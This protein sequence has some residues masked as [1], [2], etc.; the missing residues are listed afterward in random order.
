[1]AASAR[2]GSRPASAPAAKQE[3]FLYV[4]Y[5]FQDRAAVEEVKKGVEEGLRDD[6]GYSCWL[7]ERRLDYGLEKRDLV[8]RM[9]QK[10]K[11]FLICLSS[12]SAVSSLC[13]EEITWAHTA[14]KRL[15]PIWLESPK[16]MRFTSQSKLKEL[17]ERFKFKMPGV[18]EPSVPEQ[19]DVTVRALQQFFATLRRRNQYSQHGKEIDLADSLPAG[20]RLWALDRMRA[21]NGVMP[22]DVLAILRQHAYALADPGAASARS[23]ADG[24]RTLH[25][26]GKRSGGGFSR[27]SNALKAANPGDTVVIEPGIYEEHI[28]LD[29]ELRIV[30]GGPDEHAVVIEAQG[31]P[32]LACHAG[33]AAVENLTLSMASG[34]DGLST[35]EI[36][37]GRVRI[38]RCAIRCPHRG[39]AAISASRLA[40]PTIEFCTIRE[41]VNAG[42]IIDREITA[43]LQDCRLD[44]IAGDG[45]IIHPATTAQV[46][47]NVIRKCGGAGIR[48][49]YQAGG[50]IEG[51]LIEL[52]K[53]ETILS[54]GKSAIDAVIAGNDLFHNDTKSIAAIK[55]VPRIYFTAN[56]F[57][58]KLEN[59]PYRLPAGGLGRDPFEETLKRIIARALLPINPRDVAEE[60]DAIRAIR[61]DLAAVFEV[62]EY[63]STTFERAYNKAVHV[64]VYSQGSF[65]RAE[66]LARVAGRAGARVTA[67]LVVPLVSFAVGADVSERWERIHQFYLDERDSKE[68]ENE[69]LQSLIATGMA[70]RGRFKE[71]REALSNPEHRHQYPW[72]LLYAAGNL[73]RLAVGGYPGPR[74]LS[75][76]E[77]E[78]WDGYARRVADV[79]AIYGAEETNANMVRDWALRLA[80]R[81]VSPTQFDGAVQLLAGPMFKIGRGPD[82]VLGAL[83]GAREA[84]N[85]A[86]A[87]SLLKTY[88]AD[89]WEREDGG[90]EDFAFEISIELARLYLTHCGA[91]QSLAEAAAAAARREEAGRAAGEVAVYERK[92]R[93]TIARAG[94]EVRSKGDIQQLTGLIEECLLVLG[95]GSLAELFEIVSRKGPKNVPLWD[96]NGFCM[97]WASCLLDVGSEE[98]VKELEHVARICEPLVEAGNA[99]ALSWMKAAGRLLQDEAFERAV[100]NLSRMHASGRTG[101]SEA[102]SA[103]VRAVRARNGRARAATMATLLEE[104]AGLGRDRLWADVHIVAIWFSLGDFARA[105]EGL[106]YAEAEFDARAV[107]A[108]AVGRRPTAADRNQLK[109]LYDAAALALARRGGTSASYARSVQERARARSIRLH[110]SVLN[111]VARASRGPLVSTA[112]VLQPTDPDPLLLPAEEAGLVS[113]VLFRRRRPH[114]DHGGDGGEEGRRE[115]RGEDPEGGPAPDVDA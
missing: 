61:D 9:I 24:P 70:M 60:A 57:F 109:Y 49:H 39:A 2:S 94:R 63:V 17:L 73:A 14:G 76:A 77:R 86:G 99:H 50:S 28:V 3:H 112:V 71:A 51:N 4:S 83:Q 15:F 58:F 34:R 32:A 6:G 88:A 107:A 52:C 82:F 30:G 95:P 43:L 104:A 79:V 48:L 54:E 105:W 93:S 20:V 87:E 101:P 13:F 19:V 67:A 65:E 100:Q 72:T 59:E 44:A 27:I 111:R 55:E 91:L 1:M 80:S 31:H 41:C 81:S 25:V 10:S 90:M 5:A 64:L 108:R 45:I 66:S 56:S 114:R 33:A 75:A 38:S 11:A 29:K 62:E 97:R 84:G 89:Y 113:P 42:V 92:A 12:S 22:E 26:T 96:L 85:V 36:T 8:R 103:L 46:R 74:R 53:G 23:R 69:K 16:G 35:V 40:E 110:D 102:Y 98:S 78:K 37:K 7:D 18:Q 21:N 115:A 47:R 68:Q 106:R